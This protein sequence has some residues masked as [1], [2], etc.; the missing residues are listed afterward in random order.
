MG[1]DEADTGLPAADR[2]TVSRVRERSAR[3]DH[4]REEGLAR[5]DEREGRR[6]QGTDYRA[7]RAGVDGEGL[8][9]P[10]ALR[11]HD[12]GGFEVAELGGRPVPGPGTSCAHPG[13]PPQ[14]PYANGPD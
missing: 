8:P 12:G 6:N 4:R 13:R 14:D 10:W 9:A 5:P 7:G 1:E 11:R 2:F 3:G